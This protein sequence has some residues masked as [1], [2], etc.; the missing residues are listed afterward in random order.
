L[1]ALGGDDIIGVIEIKNSNYISRLFVD[2][3]YQ[4]KGIARELIHRVVTRCLDRS[5]LI[6]EITVNSSP[7][8]VPA[9]QAFG[10]QQ[11]G[12]ENIG[13]GIRYIPMV[14]KLSETES[15]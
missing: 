1:I 7:N 8:A 2:E 4:R 6:F 5:P 15:G 12:P 14:L 3:N 9:Y 11:T 13:G 10:F